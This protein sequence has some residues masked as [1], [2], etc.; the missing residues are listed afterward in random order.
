MTTKQDEEP[1][2]L[3]LLMADGLRRRNVA[4]GPAHDKS[5]IP[6][7]N[8]V[9]YAPSRETQLRLHTLNNTGQAMVIK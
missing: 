7:Q 4:S 6:T 9:S 2:F 8:V 3:S 1:N 5:N